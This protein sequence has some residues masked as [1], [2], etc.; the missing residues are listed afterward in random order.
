[1]LF[2][3]PI[4]EISSKMHKHEIIQL[5]I[6]FG[7]DLSILATNWIFHWILGFGLNQL[8]TWILERKAIYLQD[9]ADEI[10]LV[11]QSRLFLE[12]MGDIIFCG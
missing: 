7:L 5:R 9:A 11:N 2:V 8:L 3:W 6:L 1:M 4:V 12:E 10:P